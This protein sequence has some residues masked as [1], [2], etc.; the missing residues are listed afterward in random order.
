M[1]ET[2]FAV[3]HE[4]ERGIARITIGAPDQLN[5]LSHATRFALSD[6]ISELGGEP[7]LRVFRLLCANPEVRPDAPRSQS[8]RRTCC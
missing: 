8:P 3:A 1:S 4:R 2:T 7:W 5:I 6:A